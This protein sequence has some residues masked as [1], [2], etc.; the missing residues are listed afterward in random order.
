MD[1]LLDR[2]RELKHAA[3]DVE[4]ASQGLVLDKPMHDALERLWNAAKNIQV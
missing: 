4:S 1:T 2:I 3:Q